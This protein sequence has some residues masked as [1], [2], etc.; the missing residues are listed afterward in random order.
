MNWMAPRPKYISMQAGRGIAALMVVVQHGAYMLGGPGST[1]WNDPRWFAALHGTE[2]GVA[3]FFVLSGMVMLIAH[4]RD[5][6]IPSTVP[7]YFW[8]RFRRIYPIYWCVFLP[9]FLMRSFYAGADRSHA[10]PGITFLSNFALIRLPD[11]SIV[12]VPAWTLFH[13]V[14]FY[15]VFGLLLVN[16]RIG[17]LC[18][19]LWLAG[20]IF[21]IVHPA[22]HDATFFSPLHLLFGVGILTA[23]LQRR[24]SVAGR[25]VFYLG[26]LIFLV[27]VAFESHIPQPHL[28]SGVAAAMVL[29][30]SVEMERRGLLRIPPI[31]A[32]FGDASYAIYLIHYPV[33]VTLGWLLFRLSH[34]VNTPLWV[35]LVL[36]CVVSTF[37][38]HLYVERPLLRWVGS[39]SRAT[40]RRRYPV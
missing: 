3:F 30:G 17:A 6:G 19:A 18:M 20:S 1:A 22:W 16:R 15:L 10:H 12:L 32:F 40:P 29:M 4:W 37:V 14:W 13:E 23:W 25:P 7:S 39:F 11:I 27:C 2:L 9:W 33:V 36:M 38:G 8:K 21:A 5:L 31:L 26:C 24:G 34:S 28:V 35:N